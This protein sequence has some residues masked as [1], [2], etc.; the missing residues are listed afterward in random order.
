MATG[1]RVPENFQTLSPIV[2]APLSD[3]LSVPLSQQG[4]ICGFFESQFY[5]CME[6]Y[7]AKMGR[8]YCDLEHRDYQE[9]ITGDK[10]KRELKQLLLNAESF[11]SKESSIRR[12]STIIQNLD[13][14]KRI[15]SNGIALTNSFHQELFFRARS[16]F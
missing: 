1:N 8:K 13:N 15:T 2:K 9:C 6:A 4:R 11:S 5:R 14:S 16:M 10:Q 3:T 7:G 12:S